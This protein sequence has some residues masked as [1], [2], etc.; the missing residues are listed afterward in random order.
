MHGLDNVEIPAMIIAA[1]GTGVMSL[2]ALSNVGSWKRDRKTIAK[3]HEVVETHRQEIPVTIPI[4]EPEVVSDSMQ[5]FEITES[6]LEVAQPVAEQQFDPT[7]L[8]EPGFDFDPTTLLEP[9]Y[10]EETTPIVYQQSSLD[11]LKPQP[12]DVKIVFHPIT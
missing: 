12:A 1:I 4:K 7:S 3:L 6:V 2:F 9:D 8:I 10:E 5:L 11:Q